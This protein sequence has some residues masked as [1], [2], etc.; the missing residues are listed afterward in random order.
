LDFKVSSRG[1][2]Y[3]LEDHGLVK[4]DFDAAQK[5]INECRKDG[6]LPLDIVVDDGA[7]EFNNLESIDEND[8]EGEAEWLVNYVQKAHANYL[9]FSFWNFQDYYIEMLVEKIDLK[10]LLA[11]VC[12]EFHVPLANARGWS[13]LNSRAA[14]MTRF[15][16]WEAEGKRCVLLYFGDFDPAGLHIS[17]CLRSNLADLANAVG[18]HPGDLII[19]RFG[20]NHDFIVENNLTWIDNLETGSRKRLD[21]P[22]HP[23][24]RK[25]YVQDYLKKYGVRKVEANAL[26]VRPEAGRDLCRQTILKYVNC[27][28]INNF[29]EALAEQQDIVAAEVKRLLGERWKR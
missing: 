17:D 21:D 23:D 9:P 20:L 26:V 22:R 25:D 5:L 11:P 27:D 19:D 15:A 24:H 12:S 3:I 1:W 14:M 16:H 4:G 2:C 29:N 13:D 10:S 6:N 28:A 8:P 18:W 7:R